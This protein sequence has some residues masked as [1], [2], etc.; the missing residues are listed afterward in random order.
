MRSKTRP[1]ARKTPWTCVAALL[2]LG[3]APARAQ[4][5][6][7]A[8]PPQTGE[9]WLE[10]PFEMP[11]FDPLPPLTLLPVSSGAPLGLDE[12][13]GT[14][15]AAYPPLLQARQ[16]VQ[17][18]EGKLLNAEGGFDLKLSSKVFGVPIGY[19]DQFRAEV[20][21]EQPT[22]WWGA[23]FFGGY[24]L[25]VGDIPLYYGQYE[26]LD[27][28]EL[29]LGGR[30]PLLQ[31]RAVDPA[32][33]KLGSARL[34]LEAEE[35]NLDAKALELRATVAEAYWKWVASGRK[36]ALIARQVE[37]V[38]ARDEQ[39]RARV[40][41]G[42][43]P[44]SVRL[45]SRRAVLEWRQRLVEAERALEQA[46]LKLAMYWRDERGRPVVPGP[47][48]LPAQIEPAPR[49]VDGAEQQL[50]ALA[51]ERRPEPARERALLQEA[52]VELQAADNAL[53]PELDVEV[54]VAKDLGTTP[55]E[56]Y[57]SLYP[58]VVEGGVV[59]K[60]PLQRRKAKGDAQSA[61]ARREGQA[62]ALDF[63]QD[64]VSNDVLDD[65]S[66]LRAAQRR[67]DAAWDQTEASRLSAQAELRSFQLGSSD[68]IKVNL[69]EQYAI[70]AE[71]KWVEAQ[72]DHW[73]ALAR[74]EASVG[75]EL[76]GELLDPP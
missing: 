10:T 44:P 49:L 15:Q 24:R 13:L 59:F 31:G 18:Y 64:Q 65:A 22:P 43:I 48:R 4:E 61:Q 36:Y 8:E 56:V 25:G 76:P 29:R 41:S 33:A 45:E 63:A 20:M 26:T 28:G 42:A 74:L 57:K 30:L 75:G 38:E 21:L 16:K 52:E 5:G 1:R 58:W 70:T 12:V 66:A 50:Q 73:T 7:P 69:V 62:A 71:S 6:E 68:L 11:R 32:R 17:G 14:A 51:L 40:A 67:V 3:A 55:P 47:E 34:L 35:R 60:L 54:S 53:L 46:A 39:V 19:Y 72:A 37:L 23:T 9:A 27:G 2:L